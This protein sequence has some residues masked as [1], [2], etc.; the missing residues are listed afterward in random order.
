MR[1]A[2][3]MAYS[4]TTHIRNSPSEIRTRELSDP[5]AALRRQWDAL[6]ASSGYPD[7]SQLSGW[8]Q[9]RAGAGYRP[10][11][12]LAESEGRVVGGAQVF[13]RR[14]PVLGTVGYLPYGPLFSSEALRPS[15]RAALCGALERLV[16]PPVRM[17]LVQPPEGCADVSAELLRR[18]FR[19]S[20]AGIAPA[21]S[22]RIDLNRTEE[23]LRK[24]LSRRLRSW[25][26]QW[27]QRGVKVRVGSAADIPT[28]AALA[29]N[30]GAYQGFTSFS[31]AYLRS[32][33][34]ALDPGG[35]VL[36][37]VAEVESRPV[38]VE[39][40]TACGGVL[41]SRLTGIDRSDPAA[42]GLN[43]SAAV[44]WEA[45]R[46]GRRYGCR[47]FDFGGLGAAT[48][49]Q[50]LS[51][52]SIT[53]ASLPGPDQFKLGFG[54]QPFRYPQAVE[55][56]HPALRML[57]DVSRRAPAGR[58]ALERAKTFLRMSPVSSPGRGPGD[59]AESTA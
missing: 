22:L 34:E 10:L 29:A 35:H 3:R 16:R 12:V 20:E 41:K 14:L 59:L 21:A 11:Y 17:L 43:V 53:R 44:I 26:R 45:I 36:I 28:V 1:G 25:T 47:W 15:V 13:L 9:V 38:A 33:Y 6:V 4:A 8:A 56:I 49:D 5:S 18:G 39:L 23:E 32:L 48:A 27:P 42:L 51:G 2:G 54:P 31:P 50:L 24:Q 46:W 52:E 58:I 30:T 55:L 57:Y 19:R 7:V 37:L 40:L